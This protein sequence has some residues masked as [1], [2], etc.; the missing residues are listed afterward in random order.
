MVVR[1]GAGFAPNHAN[2]SP[3]CRSLRATDKCSL[4]PSLLP[5]PP[6]YHDHGARKRSFKTTPSAVDAHPLYLGVACR[7]GAG[8]DRH[9]HAQPQR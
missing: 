9:C 6:Q 4:P 8:R 5:P 3:N 2:V 1:G 7:S